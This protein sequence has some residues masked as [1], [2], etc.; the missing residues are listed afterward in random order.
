[1][2]HYALEVQF[3][4]GPVIQ[5]SPTRILESPAQWNQIGPARGVS[6]KPVLL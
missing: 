1:M 4:N 5:M 2:F 3:L 6:I